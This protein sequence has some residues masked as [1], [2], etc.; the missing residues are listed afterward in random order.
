MAWQCPICDETIEGPA[1][2]KHREGDVH[3]GEACS[4][5]ERDAVRV[6][7]L[8]CKRITR[9]IEPGV[10]DDGFEVKAGEVFRSR[11]CHVCA[12]GEEKVALLEQEVRRREIN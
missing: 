10:M 6:F 2:K 12:P 9:L 11:T 1:P 7:C 4:R 3:K 8:R 5:C